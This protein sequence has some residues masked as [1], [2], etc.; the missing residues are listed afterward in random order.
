MGVDLAEQIGA[1]C[2][3]TQL[4]L[5]G[6][7]HPAGGRELGWDVRSLAYPDGPAAAM[8]DSGSTPAAGTGDDRDEVLAALV[9]RVRPA[10][11]AV[12]T[13]PSWIQHADVTLTNVLAVDGRISGLVDFS[14]LHHTAAVCDL[15]VTLTS[16]L[17]NS[18][19]DRSEPWWRLADASVRGYQRHRLLLPEEA[20]LLGELVIARLV[21]TELVS[22]SR[23]DRYPENR[24]Y[25]TQYDAANRRLLDT[26]T[27]IQ[28]TDLQA[29]LTRS[30][31]TARSPR[32][33]LGHGA[34]LTGAPAA[35]QVLTDDLLY[36]RNS[37]MGGSLSPLF[38]RRPLDIVAGSGP[39]LIGRDGSRY[40]DAYN[41]VAVVGH[42]HPAVT[43]AVS[44]QLAVLNTHS[45]YLHPNVVELAERLI[46]TMPPGL[47]T[48][49][50]TTSGTESNEL[51]WRL[52]TEYTGNTAAIVAEQAYHGSS[53]WFA[54]LSPNEWPAGH[55]PAHVG[56]FEAPHGLSELNRAAAHQVAVGRIRSA[57]AGL[58]AAGDRPALV[59]VDAMF[60]SDGVLDAPDGFLAGLID[61]AHA[62]G[63]LFCADEVQGG[64]GRSGPRL[65]RFALDEAAVP[66]IVTL[67]KPMGAGFPISAVITRR[68]IADRLA[69]N[70]EYFSTFA[71]GAA[72]TAA[73]LAVLDLLADGEI[74]ERAVAVG[75]HL[76]AA[77]RE[78]AADRPV[79]GEVRGTGL[80]AGIDLV[81]PPDRTGRSQARMILEGLVGAGVLAGLTGADGRVL[82]VRPPLIWE[83]WH[84]D[85][86]VDALASVLDGSSGS[87]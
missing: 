12:R 23:A 83:P 33:D 39:W 74:P 5:Q 77:V 49:L 34:L 51:A 62:A 79:L 14:D 4:A 84:A 50:F 58:A 10:L 35:A 46:T 42:A 47:D 20:D 43:Q 29:R 24:A 72:G 2:A 63:A 73:A 70:Y 27:A 54:D 41:N 57:S 69:R 52:A 7:F 60:T 64:H 40:L 53:K 6:L 76:R 65:W 87:R 56:L 32:L 11:A 15:A 82:K 17:R 22:R 16:I 13:L 67:G 81:L 61:G 1:L 59:L 18:A 26:L 8:R 36:R 38:Y 19:P 9:T 80:V 31:G 37:A 71:A 3:R 44:R 21:V 85:R 28:P 55:R 45:R 86:F 25:I 78:L 48:C 75:K 30:V 68:E 66:D